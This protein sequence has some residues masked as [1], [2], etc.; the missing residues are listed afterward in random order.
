MGSGR[1]GKHRKIVPLTVLFL[2]IAF[3]LTTYLQLL[4]PNVLAQPSITLEMSL[5]ATDSEPGD[6]VSATLLFNNTGINTS[7][8][9]WVNVTLPSGLIYS[10]DNSALEGGMKTGDYN[11]TFT[12]VNVSF[13]RFDIFL[14]VSSNVLDGELMT[15]DANLD[16]LDQFTNSMP[17]SNRSVTVTARRPVLS[18]TKTAQIYTISPGQFYNY[19]ITFQNTGSRSAIQV[20][21]NDTL[22]WQLNYS[23][24]SSASIGGTMVS[25]LNWSFPNV[26]GTLSFNLSVQALVSLPGGMTIDNDLRLFY[27]N[28]NL[29]WFPMETATN[30]TMVGTPSFTFAKTADKDNATAGDLL[31][32][33]LSFSNVGLVSA[34]EVWINDT[35]PN[36]TTYSSSWPVCNSFAN[37]TC[38]WTLFGLGPGTYQL[39]LNVSINVSVPAGSIIDNTAYLNYTDTAGN[40]VGSLS[41]NDTTTVQESYLSLVIQD[42]A[43]TSTPYDALDIDILIRNQSPQPSLKA[44][45]NITF[46][47]EIQYVTD[48]S[49]VI[50][51][52]RTGFNRWEFNNVIQGNH[53]FTITSEIVM[54]TED[55]EELVVDIRLDH[56]NVTGRRLPT[57]NDGITITIR[58]PVI[59]PQLTSDKGDY[60]RSEI[61]VVT[62]HLNNTGSATA[63]EV[64]V[65]LS[66]PS[67]VGYLD[68]T[69]STIG[70]VQEGDFEFTFS[71]LDPGVH[72]FEIHF[73]IATFR[74]DSEIE[75]W[76]YV[77]YTDSNGD[78]IGQTSERV[79]FG[80]IA[81]AE[82]F[83]YL[84]LAFVAL[85][86]FAMSFAFASRRE[87][88]KYQLLMFIVP[89][90]SRLKRE[91]VM[92]HETRGMIRGYVIANPGDH[93]NSIKASLRLKNGTLAHHIHILE[94]EKIIKSV[95]DGK[96]R[97]FFPMG[98]RIA[99]RAFPTKIEKLI[100]DIVKETP[101]V[102]QKDIASQLGISQPTISYHITK[103]RK[104]KRLR[105][106]KH[107]MSMRH[108]L[109]DVKE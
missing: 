100:L 50:G 68:D 24:D 105:T 79:S 9:V 65:E 57:I 93:F 64:S 39:Q 107:G 63:S 60:R 6:A 101:G 3:L 29:I 26:V 25:F 41:S 48:N 31:N 85:I 104:A 40:P 20:L 52:S 82:E 108:F 55:G 5:S 74:D 8:L 27:D 109:E 69:S 77:N 19:T 91:E 49:A 28:V 17:S 33:T 90:F 75:V 56:T 22:P 106:E 98:M 43:M 94:R 66:V 92:D 2:M 14:I 18:I 72:S 86:A 95:K 102:T 10:G 12:N 88:V 45:L 99:D 83:P 103:L 15:V 21:I 73:D 46:P 87:S 47:Q 70:G 96:Y 62:I 30:T 71:D 78:A 61:P 53:S 36:G 84:L 44:W 38:T 76:V 42:R 58:A 37:N 51:G 89:L 35:I 80:I 32:Y 23:S 59:S 81:Q 4:V 97:R 54:D 34:K 16:Y 67:L 7:S 11:W 13:H 1:R